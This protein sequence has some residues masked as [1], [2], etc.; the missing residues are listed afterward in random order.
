MNRPTSRLWPRQGQIAR[1]T[2]V[3][4]KSPTCPDL[5]GLHVR[6]IYVSLLPMRE[7]LHIRFYTH[8]IHIYT[9]TVHLSHTY[10]HT[11]THTHTHTPF[12][13]SAV[14]DRTQQCLIRP[15]DTTAE[16]RERLRLAEKKNS[17]FASVVR[18]FNAIRLYTWIQR[19]TRSQD[20]LYRQEKFYNSCKV[21]FSVECS[22]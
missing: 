9:R 3:H 1:V 22:Q 2:G 21:A 17:N 12:R 11:H 8:V 5:P 4:C 19:E 16:R 6:T 15:D 10:T 7:S 14:R 20:Q 13:A 18:F